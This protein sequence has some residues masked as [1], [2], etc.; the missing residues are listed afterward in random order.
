MTYSITYTLSIF[1]FMVFIICT[2]M[3]FLLVPDYPTYA[4]YGSPRYSD[5]EAACESHKVRCVVD[6]DGGL[7]VKQ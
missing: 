6:A 3:Q 1:A 7:T 4:P 2:T 5:L